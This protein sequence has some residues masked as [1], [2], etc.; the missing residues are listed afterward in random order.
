M[1]Q[2]TE[3]PNVALEFL[4][5]SEYDLMALY[6]SEA[7]ADFKVTLEPGQ[8]SLE[9]GVPAPD[10][11]LLGA[12]AWDDDPDF[13]YFKSTQYPATEPPPADQAIQEDVQLEVDQQ[14][15]EEFSEVEDLEDEA[16]E[17]AKFRLGWYG[18]IEDAVIISVDTNPRGRADVRSPFGLF[19]AEEYGDLLRG[20]LLDSILLGGNIPEG[21]PAPP[22]ANTLASQQAP[23]TVSD[24]DQNTAP[25]PRPEE[26]LSETTASN[27]TA[28]PPKTPSPN[29][30]KLP[31]KASASKP[32]GAPLAVDA[33]GNRVEKRG[34][35]RPRK[36]TT[37]YPRRENLTL[38][39]ASTHVYP[40]GPWAD[41]DFAA[42]SADIAALEA[43]GKALVPHAFQIFEDPCLH[44]A[45]GQICQAVQL[46]CVGVVVAYNEG[47]YF[48]FKTGG[49]YGINR[50]YD[51]CCA[52]AE[53]DLAMLTKFK[54]ARPINGGWRAI[55]DEFVAVE[56]AMVAPLQQAG[57][58]L[59]Y[60]FG[61]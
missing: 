20:G 58:M 2:I 40:I 36:E 26:G 59:P 23:P 54:L 25:P 52:A 60:A 41:E 9:M 33:N 49:W 38:S 29:R 42:F 4:D 44:D 61:D 3:N 10:S 32:K 17:P 22:S 39:P 21:A 55:A 34:R 48:R 47:Y 6:I 31:R 16:E 45:V 28:S 8:S 13:Q 19:T 12:D 18:G 57:Q 14:L 27:L 35:G 30:R 15:R 37:I 43:A 50:N 56:A 53:N 46:D 1:L 7:P 51:Y 24:P 5:D 11:T